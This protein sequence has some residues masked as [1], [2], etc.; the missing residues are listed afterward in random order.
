MAKRLGTSRLCLFMKKYSFLIIAVVV[1]HKTRMSHFTEHKLYKKARENFKA[2]V[3]CYSLLNKKQ[4]AS[5][6]IH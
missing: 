4:Y 5:F 3:Y 2:K 6:L 1:T